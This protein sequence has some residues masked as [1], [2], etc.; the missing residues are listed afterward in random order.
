[1]ICNFVKYQIKLELS[2]IV[3][4]IPVSPRVVTRNKNKNFE[5]GK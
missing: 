3:M 5:N 1:M 4:S 2:L